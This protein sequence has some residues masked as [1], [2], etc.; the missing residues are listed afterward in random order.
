MRPIPLAAS[1]V[2]LLCASVLA[3]QQPPAVRGPVLMARDGDG[4]KMLGLAKAK[5]DVLI[6]G[7]L[8]RTSLLLTFR[9]DS[10]RV[11]EGEL[12]VPLP[13]GATVSG[14]GID[15]NGNIVDGVAVEKEQARVSYEKEVRRGI[16]PGL[17]EHVSG[18][19]FRARVYPIPARGTRSIKIQYVTDL[20]AE[21]QN[22]VYSCPLDWGRSVK[23]F[24]LHVDAPKA[25][26]APITRGKSFQSLEMKPGAS[27][28]SGEM[29][30]SDAKLAEDL[31]IQ[32]PAPA[33]SVTVERRTNTYRSADDPVD[34]PEAV[35]HYFLID[36]MAAP[37]GEHKTTPPHRIGIAW[38][39]SMSRQAADK[40]RELA[41]VEQLLRRLGDV[42]VDLV[43]VR[44]TVEK[45][46]RFS[47]RSGNSDDLIRALDSVV[48]D[49]GTDL[50]ALNLADTDDYWLLFT[51]GNANLGK[52]LPPSAFA[53]VFAVSNDD[54]A[55]H[56]ILRYT[57]EQSGGAY[58]NLKR[59]DGQ[60][61]LSAV[62]QEPFSLVS[63]EYDRDQ[64]AEVF[65]T[66]RRPIHG[67]LTLAGK[68]LAPEA[69]LTLRYGYGSTVTQSRT[70]TIRRE[71]AAQEGLVPLQWA[72]MKV[73]DLSRF[74]EKNHDALLRLGRE[75]NI[76]TPVTSLLVLE[77]AD[78]YVRYQVIPPRDRPDVFKE[79][80][81]KVEQY[82]VAQKQTHEQKVQQVLAMWDQRVKWWEAKYT[83]AADFKYQ[84]PPQTQPAIA[85]AAASAGRAVSGGVQQSGEQELNQRIQPGDRP[86]RAASEPQERRRVEE[87]IV[88]RHALALGGDPGRGRN[89][90]AA[91]LNSTDG[92]LPSKAQL[93]H[94]DGAYRETVTEATVHVKS[95]DPN[96]PYL[97][98]M[99][100]SP[101]EKAYDV[102]LEQ[103]K[104]FGSSPA[105]YL[106]CA[107][108][109]LRLGQRDLG[110]RVLSDV[111][112]LDLEDARLLRIIAHRIN[113]LGERQAAIDLFEKI[114]RLRPEEPQSFRDLALA[115]ADRADDAVN[116]RQHASLSAVDDYLRSIDLLN[117][118]IMGDWDRFQGIQ[119]V[120]LMEA[121]R[122]L[123][124]LNA[125]P[126]LRA[127]KLP[128]D[129][130]LV[131]N[132]D[133]DLRIVLTWDTDLTD[134]DLWV[135]EPSGEKCFYQHN[136]TTIGGLLSTDFTQGYGPEEY[137]MRRVMP[138][139]YTIQAQ[140]YGSRQQALVGPTTVHATVITHF[141]RPDEKRQHLTFR[142]ADA[143][144]VIDI[145]TVTPAR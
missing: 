82:Q 31:M 27:G 145:G 49:G 64:I 70:I 34:K 84:S 66:G 99:K 11:L 50:S 109:L 43:F 37:V 79:W 39:A 53:P 7:W 141:G 12:V 57:A 134:V 95:W 106:D 100:A 4:D 2:L 88:E 26:A 143:K 133:L 48:Y 69:K 111:A 103:R 125:L 119:V 73:A 83:Y 3:Q 139:T 41:L 62:G 24:S 59:L 35:D 138:G 55:N 21:N 142:L 29:T 112:E 110:L 93:H 42:D 91:G 128:L 16:D 76:A 30:T 72:Q 144:E 46:I 60:Q 32:L 121:N 86:A 44:N 14:Y 92:A 10:D 23:E 132:L 136:R 130:R 124:R 127:I 77:T 5:V 126:G 40:K 137:C 54:R 129:A 45:P 98:Q 96:T 8:A 120:A 85:L 90:D 22:V 15:V 101:P 118:V 108:Y 89:A 78:Q 68:L 117:T 87:R 105:F 33:E 71:G 104:T 122:I 52:D 19:T 94:T 6:D 61:A 97:K 114:R 25:G 47:V 56:T 9:N 18:N 36:D 81:A 80:E 123:A 17:L 28:F 74:P 131:K 140:F 63:V 102:Y 38:D 116:D 58:L 65:P 1:M 107:D 135:T 51:D 115:I 113:Q 67:R 13:E 75:F 20:T